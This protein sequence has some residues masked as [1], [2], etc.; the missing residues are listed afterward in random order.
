MQKVPAFGGKGGGGLP[1]TAWRA[2]GRENGEWVRGRR[3]AQAWINDA[4]VAT[5]A[6]DRI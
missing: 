1:E 2:I 4:M 3:T 6:P 5:L